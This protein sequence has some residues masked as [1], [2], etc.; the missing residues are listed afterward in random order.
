MEPLGNSHETERRCRQVAR[1]RVPSTS[2]YRGGPDGDKLIE[3]VMTSLKVV[4]RYVT[5]RT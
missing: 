4:G 1:Q 5:T 2:R 3:N